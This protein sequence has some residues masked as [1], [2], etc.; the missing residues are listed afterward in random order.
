MY[1]S[2]DKKN[3]RCGE[4]S[5]TTLLFQVTNGVAEIQS[6]TVSTSCGTY[7]LNLQDMVCPQMHVIA[8]E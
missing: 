1:G 2:D 5:G 7:A 4:G 6:T 3:K 8:I